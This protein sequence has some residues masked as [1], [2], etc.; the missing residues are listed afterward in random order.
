MKV[1]LNLNSNILKETVDVIRKIEAY[2]RANQIID[3]GL[4][5][6]KSLAATQSFFNVLQAESDWSYSAL[7]RLVSFSVGD[8]F[9]GIAQ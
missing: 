2:L 8:N 5:S 4:T 1:L 9:V 7:S 3:G 6:K